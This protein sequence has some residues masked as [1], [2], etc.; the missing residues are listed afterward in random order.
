MTTTEA[1]VLTEA[2]RRQAVIDAHRHVASLLEE[3]DEMPA[4][5]VFGDGAIAWSL[6]SWECP[7]GVPAMVAYIRRTIGG[8]WD[9]AERNDYGSDKMEFTRPGYRITVNREAVCTRR[10]VGST[11]VIKPAIS[12]PERTETTEIVEW[13]CHSLLSD[14]AA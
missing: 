14:G 7:E 2:E 11:T 5:I 9:K 13:D 8:K 1:P 6:Y 3:H 10:V 12:L 4:P